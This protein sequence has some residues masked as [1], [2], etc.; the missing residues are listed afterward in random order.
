MNQYKF[1]KIYRDIAKGRVHDDDLNLLFHELKYTLM[2]DSDVGKYFKNNSK[3]I[4]PVE[5]AF[6]IDAVAHNIH[7]QG[8][9]FLKKVFPSGDAALFKKNLDELSGMESS[10]EIRKGNR[11]YFTPLMATKGMLFLEK[12]QTG[13]VTKEDIIGDIK[14]YERYI[15]AGIATPAM[16]L[17]VYRFYNKKKYKDLIVKRKLNKEENEPL[18][19]GGPAS[20]VMIDKEGHLITSQALEMAFENYMKSVW[21]RNMN[22]YHSDVQAGWCLPSYISS[23]GKIFKSS[24]DEKGL[25]IVAEVRS[26]TRVSQRLAEEIIKGNIRSFS[27]GGSAL[28]T[29]WKRRGSQS[30]MQIDEMELQEIT[31]CEEGVNP[32]AHFDIIKSIIINDSYDIDEISKLM[33]LGFE[34]F[35]GLTYW[36]GHGKIL[37]KADRENS[38]TDM[39]TLELQKSMPDDVSIVVSDEIP[40]MAIELYFNNLKKQEKEEVIFKMAEEDN[41]N[42][43]NLQKFLDYIKNNNIRKAPEGASEEETPEVAD[44]TNEDERQKKAMDLAIAMGMPHGNYLKNPVKKNET[45]F[46]DTEKRDLNQEWMLNDNNKKED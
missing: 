28:S 41:N 4:S 19:V 39:L 44:Q 29:D 43:D 13:A 40:N 45:P 17:T 11:G 21:T 18:V 33:P 32:G 26:D 37:I 8:N 22:V 12:E 15:D 27:I 36:D 1:L 42:K 34:G 23:S 10:S 9:T 30:F 38:I 16:I 6:A 24:V 46:K 20:V 25:W 35:E 2:N 3:N 14:E 5:M 31:F 7:K